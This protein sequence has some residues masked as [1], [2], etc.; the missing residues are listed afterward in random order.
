MIILS[1]IAITTILIITKHNANKQV[2]KAEQQIEKT[3]KNQE[4]KQT[5]NKN[6]KERN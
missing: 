1:I 5:E 4:K 6:T 3:Y 2:I